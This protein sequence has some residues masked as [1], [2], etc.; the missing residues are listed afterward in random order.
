MNDL[1]IL[2]VIGTRPKGVYK[3]GMERERGGIS[4]NLGLPIEDQ[5]PVAISS[6]GTQI[7]LPK[8]HFPMK[9]TQAWNKDQV[10]ERKKKERKNQGFLEKWLITSLGSLRHLVPETKEYSSKTEV[11]HDK[12]HELAPRGSCRSNLRQSE[13]RKE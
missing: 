1:N 4:V 11:A 3:Y 8:Y 10:S 13:C 2:M 5:S 6:P 12:M 9:E 7:L